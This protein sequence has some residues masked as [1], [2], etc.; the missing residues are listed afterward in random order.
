M[1]IIGHILGY[2]KGEYRH[3]IGI[4]EKEMETTIQGLVFIGFVET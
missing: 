3:Y 2:I 1:G 4:T